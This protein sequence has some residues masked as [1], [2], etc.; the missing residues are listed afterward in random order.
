MKRARLTLNEKA[1]MWWAQNNPLREE[2]YLSQATFEWEK[3]GPWSAF[4]TGMPSYWRLRIVIAV[5]AVFFSIIY[6]VKDACIRQTFVMD[7]ILLGQLVMLSWVG[8][9]AAVMSL[10]FMAIDLHRGAF[11]DYKAQLEPA[12]VRVLSTGELI[13]TALRV[14]D[15]KEIWPP[16][17]SLKHEVDKAKE[18]A[19]VRK[20]ID[21]LTPKKKTKKEAKKK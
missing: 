13:V 19:A 20:A 8:I 15:Y 12:L 21:D 4:T 5:G 16:A 11:S 18:A 3:L 14:I 7:A 6:F 17:G 2:D 1:K 9:G 10:M